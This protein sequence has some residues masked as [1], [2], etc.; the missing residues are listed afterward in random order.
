[1]SILIWKESVTAASVALF[2]LEVM[3]MAQTFMVEG[4]FCSLNEFYRMNPY[5]QGKVKREHDERVALAAKAARIRPAK[6]R[7]RYH[8]HWVEENRR[9]DLDN[10]AFGKKFV[11]DGLVKAGIIPNDTHHEIAGF[12]DGFSYDSKHPRIIITIEEV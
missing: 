4:R 8:V 10:V 7:I 12:S 9:R 11:Q 6:G 2:C 5:E 3:P 1:M